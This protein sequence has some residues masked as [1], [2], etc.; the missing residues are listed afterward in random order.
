VQYSIYSNSQNHWRSSLGFQTA[1]NGNLELDFFFF[2][3][4]KGACN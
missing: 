3:A 1:S 4:S 2:L